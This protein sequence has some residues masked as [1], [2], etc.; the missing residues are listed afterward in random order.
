MLVFFT[1]WP[2]PQNRWSLYK[3]FYIAFYIYGLYFKYGMY[4]EV[5]AYTRCILTSVFFVEGEDATCAP[6]QPGPRRKTV[7]TLLYF[8][9]CEVCFS[10]QEVLYFEVNCSSVSAADLLQYILIK[11]SV[12]RHQAFLYMVKM[13]SARLQYLAHA[14]NRLRLLPHFYFLYTLAII[15]PYI[16]LSA[17][18]RRKSGNAGTPEV[19]VMRGGMHRACLTELSN[20]SW[21]LVQQKSFVSY[22][23]YL[24]ER[25]R[26]MRLARFQHK[27]VTSISWSCQ[28]WVV[29]AV[30]PRQRLACHKPYY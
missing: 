21:I 9:D 3:A 16:L 20:A 5:Y 17:Y 12:Y 26:S 15:C 19:W 29:A 4:Y 27:S 23:F 8:T 18:A 28:R 13:L 6:P 1:I 30:H 25:V 11:L 7:H 10:V 2:T 24:I 22:G 14:A